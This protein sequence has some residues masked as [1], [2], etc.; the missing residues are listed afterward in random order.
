MYETLNGLVLRSVRYK[1]AAKILTVLTDRYGKLTITDHGALGKNGK[2]GAADQILCYSEFIL[3]EIKGRYTVKEA[4]AREQ[5][6]GLRQDIGAVALGCYFAE[7]LECVCGENLADI[8]A[9]SLVLNALYALSN[10]LFPAEQIKAV[11]ELRLLASEGYLPELNRCPVCGNSAVAEPFFSPENGVVHCRNCGASLRGTS[12][13]LETGAL[14][15]MR[16]VVSVPAKRAFSFR[17]EGA[18]AENF[19]LVCERFLLRQ[20]DRNFESLNYWKNIK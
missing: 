20:L 14:Q 16:Y 11:F 12:L 19:Y 3:Q 4:R 18:E 17:L 15:A 1:E 7:L 13:R 5:F 2:S 6:L 10:S 9:L 8:E